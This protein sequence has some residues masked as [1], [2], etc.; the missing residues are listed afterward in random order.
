MARHYTGGLR[1]AQRTA[2]SLYCA[3]ERYA[4]CRPL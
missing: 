1:L 2:L 3:A 4:D